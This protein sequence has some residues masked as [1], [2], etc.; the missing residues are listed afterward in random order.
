MVVDEDRGNGM[1]SSTDMT[2]LDAKGIVQRFGG[3]SELWRRLAKHGHNISVKT[4]EKWQ[5]R[6]SIPTARLLV[7]LDLAR[8]EGKPLDVENYVIKKTL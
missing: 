7:L 2:R 3:R 8:K 4:I 1:V 6:N 5:E